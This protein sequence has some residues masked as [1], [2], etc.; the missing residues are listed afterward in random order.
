LQA[1]AAAFEEGSEWR[2]MAPTGR[3][4]LLHALADAIEEHGDE[5]AEVEAWDTGTSD[6][7]CIPVHVHLFITMRTLQARVWGW[8]RQ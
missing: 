4:A 2:N 8:Q 1:A 7:P 6:I 5:M 3:G